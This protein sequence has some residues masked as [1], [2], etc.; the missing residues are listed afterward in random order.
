MTSVVAQL[1]LYGLNLVST[2][3]TYLLA[4]AKVPYCIHK[5]G[6]A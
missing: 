1:S 5:I 3:G 4:A 2:L 6:K